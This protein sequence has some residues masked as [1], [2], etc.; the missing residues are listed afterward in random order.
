MYVSVPS[1]QLPL[2]HGENIPVPKCPSPDVLTAFTDISNANDAYSEYV[3]EPSASN[4]PILITQ[5][6]LDEIVAK[7]ELTQRKSEMLASFFKSNNLLAT[8]TKVTA[9]RNRKEQF[10]NFFTVNVEKTFAHCHDILSLMNKM[11]IRYRPG[12][13]RLFIDSSKFSLKAVLLDKTNLKPSIPIAYGTDTK[14][15]FEK[16]DHILQLVDYKKHN[17]RVCCDL[18][19]VAML[20][21]LQGGYIKHMCFLCDWDSRYKGDQYAKHDWKMR[22]ESEKRD[23]NR[24][25]KELVPPEK[26]ILPPLHIKLGIVK[27]FLKVVAKR[28]EVFRCLR[29]IFPRISDVKLKN[30]V[31]NG[32]DIR[33]LV[34]SEDFDRVLVDNEIVAWSSIKE[35]IV[36]LLGKHRSPNYEGSVRRMLDAFSKIGVNIARLD[37]AKYLP[38]NQGG[39]FQG[40]GGA[41]GYSGGGG[42]SG[43]SGGGASGGYSGGGGGRGGGGGYSGGGGVQSGGAGGYQGGGGGGGGGGGPQ[44]PIIRFE[45][46]PNQGDGSYNYLYETGN[47]INAQEEG[48]QKDGTAAQGS[49]SYTSP[50]GQQIQISYTADENGFQPQGA[51]LP[52]PPPIPPEILKALEQNAADEARGISDDGQYRGEGAGGGSGGY[53]SGPSG[54]GGYNAG[55]AGGGAPS[56]GYN[57]PGGGGASGGG[58]SN[59]Y[60][61]PAAGGGYRGQQQG[62][63]GPGG[64]SGSGTS[65]G[66]GGYRY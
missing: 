20:T 48:Y 41:G 56:G 57:A 14:E 61:A 51:H 29:D 9:Y 2:D 28:D 22:V 25:H 10:N 17:W 46:N 3:P 27:N 26:I 19:I 5:S 37:G 36:G 34:K 58:V 64:P 35:I 31:L 15:T 16:M 47:G 6:K 55:G 53:G 65:G 8:G 12:D 23:A 59:Q 49:F 1:V 24:I 44:I 11:D 7:L 32:P 4:Q 45:N 63:R 30:G 50:D 62:F 18:K 13:W 66:G 39:T 33:K 52:T 21:G 38:P 43:F 40:A 60:G 54:G 42:G